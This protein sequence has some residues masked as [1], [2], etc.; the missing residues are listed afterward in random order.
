MRIVCC[1]RHL[2][3]CRLC[4]LLFFFL[5]RCFRHQRSV[6]GAMG[7]RCTR[8]KRR[9]QHNTLLET[10]QN[11]KQIN[12]TTNGSERRQ[13]PSE[14]SHNKNT[15]TP[16]DAMSQWMGEHWMRTARLRCKPLHQLIRYSSLT[17]HNVQ[18]WI[19]H[20]FTLSLGKITKSIKQHQRSSH[21]ENSILTQTRTHTHAVLTLQAK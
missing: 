2:S 10:R 1:S 13:V 18:H 5:S 11:D 4:C 12:A 8:T 3:S 9:N 15:T 14:I 21:P 17:H 6:L 20:E 7:F 19:L 16:G